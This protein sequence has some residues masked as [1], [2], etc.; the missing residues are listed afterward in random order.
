M[1]VFGD[2][3]NPDGSVSYGTISG[4]P[5]P[6][7][8]DVWR[9]LEV[10]PGSV[11]GTVQAVWSPRGQYR[12]LTAP[13]AVGES[14]YED[15]YASFLVPGSSNLMR[16]FTERTF[17]PSD[18]SFITQ[19]RI[20]N[21]ALP[22]SGG[23]LTSEGVVSGINII[24]L[25]TGEVPNS[26]TGNLD[27]NAYFLADDQGGYTARI[28]AQIGDGSA[29]TARAVVSVT[30]TVINI[31]GPMSTPVEVRLGLKVTDEVG[32]FGATPVAQQ[33]AAPAPGGSF[34][35]TFT[36]IS[37]YGFNDLAE[38]EADRDWKANIDIRVAAIESVLQ[39]LGVTA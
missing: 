19:R 8:S 2:Q 33:P 25:L 10:Q 17:I 16:D 30:P 34:A 35:T 6:G 7:L 38:A 5:T 28:G 20:F 15:I 27:S 39:N 21:P 36:N 14:I 1:A 26:F 4:M 31:G 23:T 3:I 32:F 9:R 24:V 37:P 22:K 13:A 11:P 12:T 18:N 29:I